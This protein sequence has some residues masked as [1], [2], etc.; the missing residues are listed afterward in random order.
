MSSLLFLVDAR[1][2]SRPQP[3]LV[4]LLVGFVGAVVT[5]GTSSACTLWVSDA[6]QPRVEEV[7]A[8]PA[9]AVV[10][11]SPGFLR[12]KKT[13]SIAGLPFRGKRLEEFKFSIPPSRLW[14]E[15]PRFGDWFKGLTNG[16]KYV[17]WGGKDLM[18]RMPV[19]VPRGDWPMPILQ[20]DPSIDYKMLIKRPL[21]SAPMP[22]ETPD[23][24]GNDP[25]QPRR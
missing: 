3:R 17:P 18:A 2:G 22:G 24:Y 8:A 11:P 21:R 19:I 15:A 13:F 6:A 7:A 12:E 23:A 4:Y 1:R 14:L 9:P 5:A 16:R 20:P 25:V 10:A